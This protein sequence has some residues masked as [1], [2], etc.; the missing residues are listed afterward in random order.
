MAN[1]HLT[2]R[3]TAAAYLADD[4]ELL[5][6]EAEYQQFEHSLQ[7]KIAQAPQDYPEFK[8]Y[9]YQVAPFWHDPYVLAAIVSARA[10][11]FKATDP[12]VRELMDTLRQPRRQ[13]TLTFTPDGDTL[14][15][16]L[17]N[18]SLNCVID[19]ILD[20]DEICAYAAYL[21]SHGNRPEL[22]PRDQYQFAS[23]LKQPRVYKVPAATLVR[24]PFL[25]RALQVANQFIGYPYVWGGSNPDTSFDCSGFVDYVLD[26]LGYRYR[27]QIA[28]REVRLPVAGSTRQGVFYDGLYEK[29]QRVEIGGEQ[30]GDLIFFGGT[31]DTSYRKA[32]LSHVGFYVGDGWFIAC[33][34][35]SEG[36][37]YNN[38]SDT[39]DEGEAWRDHLVCYGRLKDVGYE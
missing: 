37:H 24:Y 38:L 13:Y 1:Q 22:F 4:A 5:A 18:Y 31:F 15:V 14:H 30:P 29:C 17:T 6:V 16:K 25:K 10:G 28:G 32:N 35:S 19:S 26:Q 23:E 39:L 33:A 36:V 20:N 3:D 34:S 7:Q 21:R 9:D 11:K 8:H 27:N 12:I 2:A